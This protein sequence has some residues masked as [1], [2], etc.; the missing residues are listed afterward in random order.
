MLE[1]LIHVNTWYPKYEVELAE[2]TH[3]TVFVSFNNLF[4][5]LHSYLSSQNQKTN[6]TTSA[7]Q[8]QKV[9]EPKKQEQV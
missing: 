5:H 6:N 7:V 3:Y 1:H 2:Q 4:S 9:E 8:Q